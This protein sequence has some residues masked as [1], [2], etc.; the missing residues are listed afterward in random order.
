MHT[1]K[2]VLSISIEK[3]IPTANQNNANP[4][5]LCIQLLFYLP[6]LLTVYACIIFYLKCSCQYAELIF[7]Y[8]MGLPQWIIMLSPT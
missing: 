3:I 1:A 8:W 7:A 4:N 6:V 2:N 5:N